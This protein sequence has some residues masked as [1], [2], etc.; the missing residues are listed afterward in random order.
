[1]ALPINDLSSFSPQNEFLKG[2][3]DAA[4]DFSTRQLTDDTVPDSEKESQRKQYIQLVS[5][6]AC[7]KGHGILNTI[8]GELEAAKT[9]R[10]FLDAMKRVEPLIRRVRKRLSEVQILEWSDDA[11]APLEFRRETTVK[12]V[13]ALE[14]LT[15]A[16]TVASSAAVFFVSHILPILSEKRK[17]LERGAHHVGEPVFRDDMEFPGNFYGV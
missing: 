7:L 2:A 16:S 13:S 15:G 8:L 10:D 9:N 3:F 12:S 11:F 5:N 17:E 1:M 14:K 4:G 6:L